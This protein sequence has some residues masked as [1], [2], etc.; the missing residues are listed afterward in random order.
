MLHALVFTIALSADQFTHLPFARALSE[1]VA[2]SPDVRGAQARIRENQALL[3]AARSGAAPQAFVGYAQAPQGG[4]TN[5]TIIQRLVTFGASA[6]LGDYFAS[7]PIVRQAQANVR[8]AEFDYK[9]TQRTERAKVSDLYYG[10]LRALATKKLRTSSLKAAL[11]L[12]GASRTRFAAGDVPRLD[13]VRAQVATAQAQADLDR[14]QVTVANAYSALS[15]ETGV[16]SNALLQVESRPV[17]A[18]SVSADPQRATLIA[19]DARSDLRSARQAVVAES[20][21]VRAA[22][23]GTLPIVTLNAGYTR[24]VDAGVNVAGPSANMQVALPLSHASH[25][26]AEAERARLDQAQARAD[27]L[28]RQIT[29]D[30]ESAARTYGA[31]QRATQTAATARAAAQEQLRATEIGYRNG[32]SSSL[33]VSDARRTY[34]Q[35]ALAEIDAVYAQEQARAVL[36]EAIG[37]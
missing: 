2:H 27:S 20:A 18:P 13:I 1:A 10:A 8:Q 5:N 36:V 25:Y 33:D 3:E 29:I 31:T 7:S 32:A 11:A 28:K 19:L 14:A 6:I 17:E 12:Q 26:R 34:I 30:V 4:S 16:S 9:N 15:L 24:G 35:A 22:E 37:P 23:R 21:A